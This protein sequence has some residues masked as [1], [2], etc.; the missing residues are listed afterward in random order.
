MDSSSFNFEKLKQKYEKD[1]HLS[2]VVL[3]DW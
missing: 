1:N 2:A 3:D